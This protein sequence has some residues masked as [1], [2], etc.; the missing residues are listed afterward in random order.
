MR[1]MGRRAPGLTRR[2]WTAWRRP[3]ILDLLAVRRAITSTEVEGRISFGKRYDLR[4]HPL[5]LGPSREE[6]DVRWAM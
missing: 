5:Q 6:R 4:V 2:E 1:W 3:A